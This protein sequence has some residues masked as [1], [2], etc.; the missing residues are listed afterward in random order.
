M[1][2]TIL[3]LVLAVCGFL[4]LCALAIMAF[5]W[6]LNLPYERARKAHNRAREAMLLAYSSSPDYASDQ[7]W[8][9]RR[10]HGVSAR[11]RLQP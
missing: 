8:F 7:A 11:R 4:W 2:S 9:P 5:N 10:R 3:L 6:L 1:L